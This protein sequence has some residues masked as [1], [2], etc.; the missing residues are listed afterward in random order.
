MATSGAS[1]GSLLELFQRKNL[2]DLA[3]ELETGA[4]TF[5]EFKNRSKEDWEKYYG[6]AGIDIHN[7][8]NPQTQG[9]EL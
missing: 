7:H 1:P 3:T 4:T 8:L 5:H 9:I 2:T 6:I